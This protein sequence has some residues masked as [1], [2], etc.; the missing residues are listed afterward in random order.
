MTLSGRILS[1]YG[2]LQSLRRALRAAEESLAKVAE[3]E[4]DLGANLKR[5]LREAEQRAENGDETA[6]ILADPKLLKSLRGG[7]ADVK[8]GRV[9]DHAE[10]LAELDAMQQT[11]PVQFDFN[12]AL[13]HLRAGKR[14]R[15][16]GWSGARQWL[17]YANGEFTLSI[18]GR[19]D[20]WNIYQSDTTA[21]D[22]VLVEEGAVD[23]PSTTD[24]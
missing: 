7:L 12:E 11:S 10:V 17:E 6:T 22:W 5:C 18:N 15:R 3:A 2:N 19:R 9:Q 8:A 14:V 20:Y 24:E 1:A 21:A 4:M 13:K 16:L 23:K